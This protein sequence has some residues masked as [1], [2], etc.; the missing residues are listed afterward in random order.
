M[1][2]PQNM[3]AAA[4]YVPESSSTRIRGTGRTV[5]DSGRRIMPFASRIKSRPIQCDRAQSI[6]SR[7]GE[8]PTT[9]VDVP[10]GARRG[11]ISA[12]W[13]PLLLL[14]QCRGG[15]DAASSGGGGALHAGPRGRKQSPPSP[16]GHDGLAGLRRESPL[17]TRHDVR[18]EVSPS[19]R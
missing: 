7:S 18:A 14:S 8:G 16:E 10:G 6:V 9:V 1:Q 5:I 4:R 3:A 17:F 13:H 15:R 2:R 11:V 12:L 19:P